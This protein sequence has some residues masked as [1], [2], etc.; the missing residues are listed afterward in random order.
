MNIWV[1]YNAGNSFWNLISGSKV[2]PVFMS[3]YD[4]RIR[5]KYPAK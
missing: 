4:N 3:D 5:D 1:K 2:V